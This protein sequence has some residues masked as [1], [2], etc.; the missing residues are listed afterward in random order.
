MNRALKVVELNVSLVNGQTLHLATR[1]VVTLSGYP[2]IS[3]FNC[4]GELATLAQCW[5]KWEA[6]LELYVGV[7]DKVQ[8]RAI[9][10]HL[11]GPGVCEIFK[12]Y[13]NEVK[14]DAKEFDKAMTCLSNHFKVKKNLPLARQKLLASKPSPGETINNFVTHLKSLAEH[15]DNQVRYC[16][17]PCHE[18]GTEKQIYREENLSLSKLFK[19]VLSQ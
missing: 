13:P 10:L 8:K 9:L 19:I 11:A 12:M 2:C 4:I 5:D 3:P 1:M 16:D 14:G 18:Q 15:C 6:E 17:F 7:E